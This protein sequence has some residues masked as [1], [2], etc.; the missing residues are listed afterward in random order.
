[1]KRSISTAER[2]KLCSLMLSFEAILS[3]YPFDTVNLAEL[4]V[5]C[6]DILAILEEEEEE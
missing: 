2:V 5:F 4:K 6:Q 3:R 1:M